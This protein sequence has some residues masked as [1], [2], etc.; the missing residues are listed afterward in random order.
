MLSCKNEKCSCKVQNERRW[1]KQLEDVM[2]WGI[3][4]ERKGTRTIQYPVSLGEQ[5]V[6]EEIGSWRGFVFACT[7]PWTEAQD[8][9]VRSRQ[10]YKVSHLR[11]EMLVSSLQSTCVFPL[12][13]QDHESCNHDQAWAAALPGA[14]VAAVR[15]LILNIYTFRLVM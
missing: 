4:S 9:Y 10:I 6:R 15:S 11:D 7:R 14:Q 13:H 12:Y 3:K 8:Q 5:R 2:N 1:A